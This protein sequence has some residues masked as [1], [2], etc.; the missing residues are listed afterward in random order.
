[1]GEF[2]PC[3]L[4]GLSTKRTSSLFGL[5]TGDYSA[6]EG[7]YF[8]FGLCCPEDFDGLAE[9]GMGSVDGLGPYGLRE[10]VS[11]LVSN[12]GREDRKARVVN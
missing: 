8:S 4:E 7:T 6:F 1:M 5:Y 2:S 11:I 9:S 12:G 3:S 10:S